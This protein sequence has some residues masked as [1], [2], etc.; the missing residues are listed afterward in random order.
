M[1]L[2]AEPVPEV[3]SDNP[4]SGSINV[5]PSGLMASTGSS[6]WTVEEMMSELDSPT[7]MPEGLE[8]YQ[9]ER[10]I[11]ARHYKVE[12]E[13]RV[14]NRECVCVYCD[15]VCTAGEGDGNEASRNECI[16]A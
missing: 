12:S 6:N 10:F 7:H 15:A 11:I 9:W 8:L 16:L 3:K 4:S 5:R 13:R 2:K 1:K 14:R